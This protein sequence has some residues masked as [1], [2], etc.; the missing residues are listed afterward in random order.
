MFTIYYAGNPTVMNWVP[1]EA[2]YVYK[3]KFKGF[4]FICSSLFI[5]STKWKF[6][7]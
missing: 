3:L 5:S 6:L 7:D 1:F 4:Y 2:F